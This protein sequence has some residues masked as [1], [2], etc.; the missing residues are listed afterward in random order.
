MTWTKPNV[1]H[2]RWLRLI[3]AMTWANTWSSRPS[4]Y[5]RKRFPEFH[6]RGWRDITDITG[7]RRMCKKH[8]KQDFIYF[9]YFIWMNCPNDSQ[10]VQIISTIVARFSSLLR[11]LIIR[12]DSTGISYIHTSAL[13]S[14]QY[15]AYSLHSIWALSRMLQHLHLR[16]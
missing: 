3:S 12:Q 4:A 15:Q 11:W 6:C 2:V 14:L 10:F 9:I 8:W 16:T 7:Q 1:K 5:W 13:V